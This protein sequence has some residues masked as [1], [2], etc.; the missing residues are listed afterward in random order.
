MMGDRMGTEQEEAA[1]KNYMDGPAT[2]E[3]KLAWEQRQQEAGERQAEDKDGKSEMAA[4][5]WPQAETAPGRLAQAAGALGVGPEA[6]LAFAR[7]LL[8][9]ERAAGRPSGETAADEAK[10]RTAAHASR[11]RSVAFEGR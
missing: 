5:A 9:P 1:Y 7:R 10:P 8:D 4:D 3:A 11:A 2:T 6:D